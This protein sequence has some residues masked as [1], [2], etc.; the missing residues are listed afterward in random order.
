[1]GPAASCAL[2]AYES[3]VFGEE[4]RGNLFSS[5]FNLSKVSR[6]ILIPDGATFKTEDSDFLV[7]D[8][9]DFHPTRIMEDADGSL[10]VIDTGG[11]YKLCCP[12]SQLQKPDVLGAIYRIRAVKTPPQDDPRGL[13]LNWT[14]SSEN[15]L[16]ERLTDQR[17]AVQKRA[18][19]A[20]AQRENR[21]LPEL[22]FVLRGSSSARTRAIW[23]LARIDTA[24]SR[25]LVINALGDRDE[26]VRQAAIHVIAVWREKKALPALVTIL[27]GKSPQNKR[28]AAEALG[29]LEDSKAIPALLNIQGGLDRVLE[30]SLIYAL[31]EINDPKTTRAGL[32]S[33]DPR[34]RKIAMT[35]LD[36]MA[37]KTLKPSEVS[38]YLSSTNSVLRET[39]NWIVSRHN[40]WGGELAEYFKSRLSKLS[41]EDALMID[42][43]AGLAKSPEV[44]SLLAQT[45]LATDGSPSSKTTALKSMSR[46]GVKQAPENW[47]D[48]VA[49]VLSQHLE[50]QLLAVQ[51]ARTF[52]R[53]NETNTRLKAALTSVALDGSKPAANRLEALLA[54]PAIL[55]ESGSP[56]LFELLLD[57]VGQTKPIAERSASARLLSRAPLSSSQRL[58]LAAAIEKMGPMELS[59]VLPAFAQPEPE[60]GASL[61]RLLPQSSGFKGLRVDQ[62]QSVFSK[63]DPSLQQKAEALYAMLNQDLKAQQSKI[64]SLL[65]ELPEGDIRK[66]QAIFNGTK[67][68]CSSCHAIGYLGGKLG[69]DLTS[70]GQ[71]RS[72]R[73]LLEAIIYPSSSFVRS[74]EPQVVVTREGTELN[75]IVTQEN[76]DELVLALGPNSEQRIPRSEIVETKPGNMSVMPS[77]L[78]EVISKEE[79]ADLLAFLKN[80]K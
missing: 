16:A 65:K 15:V 11:W 57:S 49:H 80:T 68:A 17:L 30:H 38:P 78:N 25:A 64:E 71:I 58:R 42:Q 10:I 76:S 75:G 23:T 19:E 79:L 26:I 40:D 8:S 7:S 34:V 56:E 2:M 77:G 50:L 62:L 12:T 74:Y 22:E 54:S 35:A 14:Q 43:L 13:K 20:L 24:E 39:A 47:K 44:Q 61:V 46:A 9:A 5:S 63:H 45:L 41:T 67:A 70:V 66:G 51:T 36:Q 69:P 33:P 28:A 32:D 37:T 72:R 29:R 53:T 60:L 18:L 21:A 73:D 59:V 48:G 55:T 31:I 3:G 4:F 27:D 1:M 52:S 6:H